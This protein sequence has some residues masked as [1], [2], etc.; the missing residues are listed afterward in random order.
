MKINSRERTRRRTIRRGRWEVLVVLA[1]LLPSL[2]PSLP[3]LNASAMTLTAPGVVA[4]IRVGSNP[5]AVA[6]DPVAHRAYVANTGDGSL[7]VLD[8]TRNAIVAT[9]PVGSGA[10]AGPR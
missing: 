9:I 6:T 3:S 1:A 8:T 4:T 10:S 5:A 2:L 7:S